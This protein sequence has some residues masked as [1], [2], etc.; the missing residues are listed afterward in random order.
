LTTTTTERKI[1]ETTT[2]E[3]MRDLKRR[4]NRASFDTDET[5]KARILALA[6]ELAEDAR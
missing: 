3:T 4:A 5:F 2:N 1:L 6:A